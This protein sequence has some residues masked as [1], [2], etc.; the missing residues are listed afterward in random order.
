MF[1]ESANQVSRRWDEVGSFYT[2][3]FGVVYVT[4]GDFYDG[5]EKGTASV[6]QILCQ[7]RQNCY[8][9]PRNDSTRLRG[10]KLESYL[11]VSMTC[12]VQVRSRSKNGRDGGT[13]VYNREGTTSRVMA[14]DRPYG[15]FYGFYSVSLE[16][17][18]STL[19]ED[20]ITQIFTF[21]TELLYD[22]IKARFGPTQSFEV[23]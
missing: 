9:N 22:L 7:S 6:H 4:R 20:L 1:S 16:T 13:G 15:K 17:F 3:L 19:V 5:S 23:R 14:A 2:R 8:G 10:P 11:G 21:L 18:G 12:P